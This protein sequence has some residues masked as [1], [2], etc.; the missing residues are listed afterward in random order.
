VTILASLPI[1]IMQVLDVEEEPGLSLGNKHRS[2]SSLEAQTAFRT[3]LMEVWGGCDEEARAQMHEHRAPDRKTKKANAGHRDAAKRPNAA[4][5][6]QIP[7]D[8]EQVPTATQPSSSSTES[9]HD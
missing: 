7:T 1:D 2:T 3:Y 5:H 6:A 4:K 8:T 9:E